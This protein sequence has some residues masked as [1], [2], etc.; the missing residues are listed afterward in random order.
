[1]SSDIAIAQFRYLERLLL[2]HGHWC[3]RRITSMVHCYSLLDFNIL[4]IT[5]LISLLISS[6]L[7]R[8]ICYF[9]YKNIAFGFTLFLYEACT[10][11][12]GQPEYN[13]WFMSLYNV[14]FSSLP[15]VALG[16][17]DQDVSARYC[18]KVSSIFTI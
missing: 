2:V 18:L 6:L 16:V 13:D 9:F 14:F 7:L 12:S 8:Q 17:F 1:M 5:C 4:Y 10:S 3:Y 15:V 11:F